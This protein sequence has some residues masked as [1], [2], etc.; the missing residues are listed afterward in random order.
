MITFLNHQSI[1]FLKAH[2]KDEKKLVNLEAEKVEYWDWFW[3]DKLPNN[4]FLP[5]LNL[6]QGKYYGIIEK[7][8]L[9]SLETI[10]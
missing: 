10:D 4:L 8:P 6:S 5:L 2:C 3:P 7:N 9:R 1:I